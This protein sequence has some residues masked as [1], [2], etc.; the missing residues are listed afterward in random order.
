MLKEGKKLFDF[1][2]DEIKLDDYEKQELTKLK[3]WIYRKS[4]GR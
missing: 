1:L 4:A 3:G 2:K